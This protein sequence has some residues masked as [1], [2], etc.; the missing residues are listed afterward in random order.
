MANDFDSA[1]ADSIADMIEPFAE[2]MTLNGVSVEGRVLDLTRGE[3][4]GLNGG[5]G[6][7]VESEVEMLR[8]EWAR[9]QGK[10]GSRLVV[11]GVAY[12]VADEPTDSPDAG[13]VL[14]RLAHLGGN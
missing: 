8:S 11:R 4:M 9:A 14:L 1:W 7:D 13:S 6:A 5:R 2:A 3:R 10:A 12:E